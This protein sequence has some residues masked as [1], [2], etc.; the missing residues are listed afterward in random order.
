MHCHFALK[1]KMGGPALGLVSLCA[2]KQQ[3]EKG[4][5]ELEIACALRIL[6]GHILACFFPGGPIKDNH[7]SLTM[8]NQP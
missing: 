7:I 4:G 8:S 1:C 6:T 3:G 5:G 2:I